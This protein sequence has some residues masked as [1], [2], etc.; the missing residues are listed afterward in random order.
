M[1][2][3]LIILFDYGATLSFSKFNGKLNLQRHFRISETK[4]FLLTG[5]SAARLFSSLGALYIA[6]IRI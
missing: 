6:K 3:N 4:H 2:F 1:R 5:Y